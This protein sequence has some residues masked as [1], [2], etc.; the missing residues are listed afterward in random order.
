[1][2]RRVAILLLICGCAPEPLPPLAEV[3]IEVATDLPVPAVAS[4]LRIDVYG[5][6]GRWFESRDI[7]RPDLRDWPVSFSVYTDDVERDARAWVRLRIY[8]EGRVRDYRGERFVDWGGALV[9]PPPGTGEP[10]LLV[11]GADVTPEREPEPLVTVDRLILV[12]LEPDTL[13]RVSVAL[14]A[15]CAG[16]MPRLSVSGVTP[17]MGEAESCVALEKQREPVREIAV[18]DEV[19]AP[20]AWGCSE[21]AERACIPGGA[22]I[23]GSR[24][25]TLVPDLSPL[26]ERVVIHRP[27]LIDKHEVTVAR[28]REARAQGFMPSNMPTAHDE[29]LGTTVDTTCSFSTTDLGREVYALSCVSWHAARELCQFWGGDLPSEA[30]WEWMATRASERGRSRY[31]WG[32]EPPSCERAVHGRLPLSGANGVCQHQ[33]LGPLPEGALPNDIT[34][35]GVIGA[36][37]GLDEWVRDSYQEYRSACWGASPLT[38]PGCFE[39]GTVRAIRGGSWAS[40]PTIL[41]SAARLGTDAVG[42]ASFIGFRCV[43]PATEAP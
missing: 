38:D 15:V 35:D 5:D 31:P 7:A 12:H 24:E 8:P 25:L 34:H 33:G 9:D 30:Q 29:P 4:R 2:V 16:T 11:D 19:L 22:T 32:D 6:D 39:E 27:F 17:V 42:E 26:P 36:A 14:P 37:G 40:P 43:Y 18:L 23:L 1:M 3:V 20:S 21:D 13:S 28:F 10:R 41:A